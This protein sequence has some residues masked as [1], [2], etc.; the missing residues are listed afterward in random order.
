MRVE[1]PWGVAAAAAPLKARLSWGNLGET[2][3]ETRQD[4]PLGHPPG[5]PAEPQNPQ[6]SLMGLW[7]CLQVMW[8]PAGRESERQNLR[9]RWEGQSNSETH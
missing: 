4:T 9:S 6:V 2:P 5:H 7:H 3:T 1:P 8:G